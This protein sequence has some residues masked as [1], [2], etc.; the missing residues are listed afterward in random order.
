MRSDTAQLKMLDGYIGNLSLES[1]HMGALQPY[2]AARK[3]EGIKTQTINH[4]LQVIRH[5]LNLAAGEWIDEYGLTWL[6][7]APKIKLLLD[8]DAKKP[9]PLYWEE[10]D[11]LFAA[12]PLHLRE[13]AL[14]AVNAGCRDGAICNL[15][16]KW[17]VPT[18]STEA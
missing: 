12:L 8:H 7:T 6:A 9:Y 14:F 16:W 4:A 10:Q 18:H 1:I 13:M 5:V 17:E 11:R 2:I 3:L 15:R